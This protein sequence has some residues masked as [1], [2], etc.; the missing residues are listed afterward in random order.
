MVTHPFHPW[1]GRTVV[2]RNRM[3]VGQVPLVRIAEG[4]DFVRGL[5]LSWTSER[6]VDA[7]EQASAG[8]SWFRIDDLVA[9]AA[10]IEAIMSDQ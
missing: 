3:T 1:R 8:R 6:V 7:F 2:V 9:L 5:P 10:L 4:P